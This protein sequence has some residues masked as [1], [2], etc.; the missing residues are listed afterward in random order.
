MNEKA[1]IYTIFLSSGHGGAGEAPKSLTTNEDLL[2]KLQNEC[3][4]INFVVRD[5]T[6]ADTSL[7]AVYSELESSEEKTLNQLTI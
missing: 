2:H 7:E 6:K 4:G 3:S 1:K 5:I